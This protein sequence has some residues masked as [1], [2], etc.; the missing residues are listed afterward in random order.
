[1]PEHRS[2][3][4]G[5]FCSSTAGAPCPSQRAWGGRRGFPQTLHHPNP[6]Q[7]KGWSW[8]QRFVGITEPSSESVPAS[9]SPICSDT[10]FL[11]VTLS[12]KTTMKRKEG[13]TVRGNFT[14]RFRNCGIPKQNKTS[15]QDAGSSQQQGRGRRKPWERLGFFGPLTLP[16][17]GGCPDPIRLRPRLPLACQESLNRDRLGRVKGELPVPPLP[18][19]AR[20][21]YQ[22][23]QTFRLKLKSG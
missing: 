2:W 18:S 4:I 9:E 6:L 20:Y 1:M 17:P 19:P 5:I 12:S 7:D 22:K 3:S 14:L 13:A 10:M 8:S 21:Y 11:Q 16:P 15:P 23:Y